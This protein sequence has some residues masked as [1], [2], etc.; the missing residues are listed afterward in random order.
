MVA[1]MEVA[2]WRSIRLIVIIDT[3]RPETIEVIKGRKLIKNLSMIRADLPDD[4]DL[5]SLTGS[6]EKKK[7]FP[8]E[9]TDIRLSYC[10]VTV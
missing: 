4:L 5:G 2:T 1:F 6:I 3:L 8:N 10:D 9:N 7:F